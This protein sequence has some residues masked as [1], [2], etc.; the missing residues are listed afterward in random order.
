MPNDSV[1]INTNN[2]SNGFVVRYTDIAAGDDGDMRITV[3]G[4]KIYLSAMMLEAAGKP[5]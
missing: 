1:T 5:D 2:T 3:S 4:N